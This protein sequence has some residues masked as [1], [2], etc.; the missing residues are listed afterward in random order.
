[1]RRL[2]VLGLDGGTFDLVR[3]WADEGRMPTFARVLDGGAWGYLRSV[4]NINTAPA[5]TTFMTGVNPGK[6]GVFWFAEE[7]DE[8]G[9]V[10]FVTAS[11]RDAT[12]IW[13]LLSDAGYEV[14]VVN[15]PLTYPV[16]PVNGVMLA[17]FD[18]PSTTAPRFSHP[19]GLIG[20]LERT[21]GEY[22][23]NAAVAGHAHAG[24]RDRVVEESL[25]AEESRLVAAL[26]LMRSR[27]WDV[28]MYMIKATDQAAHYLWD[29]GAA[30]QEALWP[31]YEYADAALARL[32]DAAGPECGLLVMS[33]HGMGWRQPA[34]EFLNEILAQL[35]YLARKQATGRSSTWSAFRV[36][37]RLGPRAKGFLKRTFPNSYRRFGYQV[38]FGNIEWSGTR[39]YC[40]NTRSCVWVN[41]LGRNP[42]GIVEADDYKG[43][44]DDVREML[45]ELVDPETGE[46]V[47]G[48]VWTPEEIYSGPHT[49][50]SP[51]LQIDWRFDRPVSG[52][53]Y[54]GRL[55]EAR[56]V[57][58]AKGTMNELT[59][60]HRPLGVLIANG[61]QFRA[62]EITGA[63]L[64]D[65]APT[66]LHLAGLP[67]PDNMD[68][69]VLTEALAEPHASTPVS[70]RAPEAHRAT[71]AEEY[72][73]EEAAEVEERLRSLGYL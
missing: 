66:I 46:R 7:G 71:A 73:A 33:D 10:R 32:L 8:P 19:Q 56:A 59:G 61:P 62:G 47:V 26:H 54:R 27:S 65:I 72:S 11:D 36:A 9:K 40:D 29:Y 64:E 6:H 38:R 50:E 63:R 69:R 16:E 25:R 52:L 5:W 41:L 23:L 57:R 43:I 17:G 13:T 2:L 31:I 68:G 42:N 58:A 20:E 60:A 1:L 22:R 24:R 34:P 53:A 39:A 48:G 14:C 3:P 15:V 44:V 45:L 67:V 70:F 49:G 18:A 35:G 21:T 37:K 12:T 28:F 55:G 4:P 51:D 30:S